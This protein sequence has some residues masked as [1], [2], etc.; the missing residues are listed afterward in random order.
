M[1]AGARPGVPSATPSGWESEVNKRFLMACLAALAVSAQ[2]APLTF[3]NTQF[4]ATAVALGDGA[5]GIDS[6]S[7]SDGSLVSASAASGSADL[8]TAGA[9]AGPG[10]L[11]TSADV[12]NS[13]SGSGNAVGVAYFMGSFFGSGPLLFN[14]DFTPLDLVTG[15]GSAT[16]SLFVLLTAGG[17]TLFEDFISGPWEFEY[18]PVGATGNG[19]LELTLTSEAVAGFPTAGVGN[20]NAFGLVTFA[21]TVPLPATLLLVIVGLGALVVT[22]QRS[23]RM[24]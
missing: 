6:Q 17:T 8:A 16:T 18:F 11:A 9:I 7:S 1:Y 10:L 20:G 12:S 3:F 14:I 23:Q 13:A 22:R 5:A 19:T 21:A 2:A 15:T 24:D 4:E